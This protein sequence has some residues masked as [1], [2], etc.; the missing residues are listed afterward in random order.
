M[1]FSLLFLRLSMIINALRIAEK[2]S[3]DSPCNN[4]I[5]DAI[6]NM[7]VCHRIDIKTIITFCKLL[8]VGFF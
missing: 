2:Y 1:K 3:V 6:Q 8:L 5:D 4:V 7:T